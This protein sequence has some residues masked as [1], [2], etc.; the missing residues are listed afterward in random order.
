MMPPP[1]LEQLKLFFVY[2]SLGIIS[3][4]K[5]AWGRSGQPPAGLMKIS[6][7]VALSCHAHLFVLSASINEVH[8]V[9]AYF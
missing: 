8:P 1:C 7:R 9:H 4:E 5:Q 3:R 6:C 2:N